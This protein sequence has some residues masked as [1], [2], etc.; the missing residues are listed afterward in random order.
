[1]SETRGRTPVAWHALD[2]TEVE[3]TLETSE[4]GLTPAE[5]G[6]RLARWGP[7]GLPEAP[8]PSALSVLLKQFA[9]PLVAILLVAAVVTAILGETI[10]TGVIVVVILVGA[11]LGFWQERRAERSARALDRLL[12]PHTHAIRNGTESDLESR[13]L[14]PGDRVRLASGAQ[15]PADL[16]LAA[17]TDLTIDESLLTGESA[18]VPKWAAPVPAVTPLADRT[19][20]AHAGTVVTRGRGW[21][22]VVA[23]GE[24]T[25]LGRIA[26]EVRQAPAMATPLQRRMGSLARQITLLVLAAAILSFGIGVLRG[27]GAGEMF[28]VAVALAVAAV[29]EGL[30]VILTIALAV[31]VHRMARRQAIIRQ[32]LAVE[33]LGSTTVIASDKT[34]TLTENRMTVQAIW[35]DR[36]ITSLPDL[37]PLST[38]CFEPDRRAA[39]CSPPELTLLTGVL[40]NEAAWAMT[41]SGLEVRG[42]PTEVALLQAAHSLGFEPEAI[43]QARPVVAEIPF[44]SVRQYSAS[45]R[46][47][48]GASEIFV[49][50]APERVIALCSSLLTAAGPVPLDADMARAAADQMAARGL[51]VLAMA[52]HSLSGSE[53]SDDLGSEPSDLVLVGMQGMMDPPRPGVREAIARCNEAGIRVIMITGD[54]AATA[55]AV[56]R[57]LGIGR[58]PRVVT[59]DDLAGLDAE[60]LRA[61][62]RQHEVYARIAPEQKLRIVR[63]L[64]ADREIVA[65]T[66]DGVND[67]P[68]LKAADIGV[69]MGKKGSDVAREAAQMI[70]ADDN[71]IT[72]VSAVEEGRVTFDNVR[73]TTYFLVATGAAEVLIILG[74]LAVGWPT[75]L[76]PA[77][78]L[79]LNLVTDGLEDKALAIE[80]GEP[81]VL[82]RPPR[83]LS[84]GLISRRLWERTVLTA[85]TIASGTLAMF[86]WELA[87]SGSLLQAQTVALTTLVIFEA[88][89][90]GNARSE[91]RSLFRLS[92]FSNRF[93]LLGTVAAVGIHIAALYLPPT[94][95][96][97]RV[98]PIDL[99]AWIRI[100]LVA[101]TVILVIELHKWLRNRTRGSDSATPRP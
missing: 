4:A 85:I 89:Q 22:Y 79:W 66:G 80:P 40:A 56:S 18:P 23:T 29:P 93:L 45:V 19:N 42:D 11:S 21:G 68:A 38:A 35:A 74:A 50:G 32:L 100:V 58:D 12:A 26:L 41:A 49:K 87:Q 95:F 15:V 88:F 44:E 20:L 25:A 62:V 16:W 8:P 46:A 37:P 9:S 81:D 59:G 2:R 97:L 61:T 6:M 90:A 69:A 43:R 77:Q 91:R 94:Q 96:I 14:V 24:A 75:P 55:R 101:T 99:A 3:A 67:A 84:E 72:I 13:E 27:E 64:Q 17:A 53:F 30:P 34:G 52:Y 57:E 54:H 76:L 86:R 82:Q 71:F 5:A 60:A 48:S 33:T 63:A 31:G 83:P 98:V 7:N 36:V 1:M 78:I 28:R 92:P 39:A 65:V 51:R 70:L 73:R 47:W 10:D